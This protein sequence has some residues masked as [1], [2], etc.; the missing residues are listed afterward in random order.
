[1]LSFLYRLARAFRQEHGYAPNVVVMNREHYR[2]LQA[3]LPDTAGYASLTRFIGMD[4]ILSE[5]CVHPHV[6]WMPQ[7]QRAGSAG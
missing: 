7:A 5:D 6:A 3:S 2:L 1:M 4:V